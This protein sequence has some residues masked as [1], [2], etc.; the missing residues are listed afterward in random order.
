MVGNKKW[1]QKKR[2]SREQNDQDK[3]KGKNE[4]IVTTIWRTEHLNNYIRKKRNKE[5][6]KK[7]KGV[8]ESKCFFLFLLFF[9]GWRSRAIKL[10]ERRDW[11]TITW[12]DNQG[13]PSWL[14]K[15]IH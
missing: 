2:N 8:E 15:Y 3:N 5:T 4:S 9:N 1:S 13:R 14:K 10:E 12:V 11:R 6:I 7:R